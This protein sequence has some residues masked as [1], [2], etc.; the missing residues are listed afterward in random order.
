MK[1]LISYVI[2][3]KD[4]NKE[5]KEDSRINEKKTKI[6]HMPNIKPNNGNDELMN[7]F[8]TRDYKGNIIPEHLRF[9]YIP[10]KGSWP[11]NQFER[12]LFDEY[13]EKRDQIPKPRLYLFN[14]SI[15]DKSI[16]K[17]NAIKPMICKN[18]IILDNDSIEL[19]FESKRTYNYEVSNSNEHYLMNIMKKE[20]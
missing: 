12:T 20:I 9:V 11:V 18:N 8:K 14:K 10:G 15:K 1:N 7:W 17:S 19:N 5:E 4:K 2:N 13:H 16:I 3:K 6:K